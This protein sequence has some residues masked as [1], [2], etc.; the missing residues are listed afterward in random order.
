MFASGLAESPE[1]VG[2]A[3][4]SCPTPNLEAASLWLLVWRSRRKLRATL[5]P[6]PEALVLK[7]SVQ[8]SGVIFHAL[9]YSAGGSH[10]TSC[11]Q[12]V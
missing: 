11:M 1:T 9:N 12:P 8:T 7:A 2:S 10:S 5:N 6:E 4:R 3:S